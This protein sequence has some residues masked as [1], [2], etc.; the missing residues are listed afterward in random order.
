MTPKLVAMKAAAISSSLPGTLAGRVEAHSDGPEE[1]SNHDGE[2]APRIHTC[3]C[4]DE[5]DSADREQV[6]R[7]PPQQL[8][9]EVFI[10]VQQ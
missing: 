2:R 10:S 8:V 9:R 1:E 7:H 3:E 4:A 5:A 6:S